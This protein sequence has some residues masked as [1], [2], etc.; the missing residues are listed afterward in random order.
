MDGY[1]FAG[2]LMLAVWVGLT[3]TTDVPGW[4]H[5]LLTGG[6]FVIIWRIVVRGTTSTK[7]KR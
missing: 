6:V 2:V 4:M 1:L 3:L 5:L 7:P